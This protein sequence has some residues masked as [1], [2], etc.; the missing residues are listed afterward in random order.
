[1]RERFK[2]LSLKNKIFLSIIL[3]I[4]IISI[5]IAL[6]ARWILVSS[7]TKELETRGVAIAHS[8]AERGGG[9][10]LDKNYPRLLALIFD[11]AKLRERKELINYIFITDQDN[12]VISHT[13]THPFPEKLRQI[14]PLGQKEQ[15]VRLV[16]VHHKI[17]YDIA[18]SVKEGIYQIGTV[19]VGLNKAHIDRLVSKLRITFLGFISLVIV[20]IFWLSHRLA[21]TITQPVSK[22]TKI[23]DTLSRGDFDI[24]LDMGDAD[25][26]WDVTKCPAY[27]DTN[28]PC[29]HLDQARL[30]EDDAEKRRNGETGK[31]RQCKQCLFYRK[32]QGDELVQLRDSFINMVWSIRLYRKRLQE[33]EAKY[34]SLFASGPDPIFVIQ[35]DDYAILDINPRAEE[36]Y[37]FSKDELLG[38][39]FERLWPEC[40][41]VFAGEEDKFIHGGYLYRAKVINYKKGGRPFFVSIHACP[42]SYAGKQSIILACVDVTEMIEKDAQLIQASKMKA[43]GEMSAGIAHELNQPLNAIKMGSE[44]LAMTAQKD[45]PVEKQKLLS[46]VAEITKQVDRASE[47]I[48]NLR[49]FSRKSSLI[50]EKVNVNNAVLGVLSI[51]KQQIKLQNIDFDLRLQ[52][53]LIV[54]AHDN[55]LQQVFFN[56][57]TNA[58]DA[59]V[60]RGKKAGGPYKGLIRIST[61]EREGQVVVRFEDNGIGIPDSARDKIFEPFYTTKEAGQGMG[62]GLAITYGIVKDYEGSIDI[63]SVVGQGT[64]I[65]ISFPRG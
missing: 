34:R 28:M 4:L 51:L 45:L 11:E 2:K 3:V 7:L 63:H 52:E 42:I 33:S 9:F 1:M 27:I 12:N 57:I 43:L 62:L 31:I 58:R 22:L 44:F 41:Q 36:V 60:E 59:I 16:E 17:T 46:I 23:A 13:F 48:K 25:R 19:H 39:S 30:L 21:L 56:I 29:W 38:Q 54:L 64:R 55:R 65:D 5:A 26:E 32:R 10:I 20:F 37:D 18:V 50:K 15:C 6:L 14:N 8:I 24:A 49:A 61:F 47:I 53:D 35:A 40:R